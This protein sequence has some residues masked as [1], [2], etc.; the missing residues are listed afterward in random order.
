VVR[1]LL[2]DED[3]EGG[4][5]RLLELALQLQEDLRGQLV[6]DGVLAVELQH[7]GERAHDVSAQVGRQDV[8]GQGWALLCGQLLDQ[9]LLGLADPVLYADQ[10]Q[11][12]LQGP[13]LLHPQGSDH[14]ARLVLNRL[15]VVRL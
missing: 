15:P 1:E 7:V 14:Q 12:E 9:Q 3:L 4:Q 5:V 13:Q 10:V 2:L 6:G 11:Q 8:R